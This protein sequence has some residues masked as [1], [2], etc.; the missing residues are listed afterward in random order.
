MQAQSLLQP[1]KTQGML[2]N[3]YPDQTAVFLAMSTDTRLVVKADTDSRLLN[4]S[5]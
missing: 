1:F 3:F 4:F 2:A 5:L